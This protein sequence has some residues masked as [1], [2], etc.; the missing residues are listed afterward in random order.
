[1]R[2]IRDWLREKRLK[3]LPW[4][5]FRKVEAKTPEERLAATLSLMTRAGNR[6]ADNLEKETIS[7]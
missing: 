6:V 5:Y 2:K 4:A 1:M 7:M 3:I